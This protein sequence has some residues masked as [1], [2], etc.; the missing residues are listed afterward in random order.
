MSQNS[1]IDF[2]A[3]DANKNRNAKDYWKDRLQKLQFAGYFDSIKQHVAKDLRKSYLLVAP[4]NLDEM[5][6][7]MAPSGNSRHIL[8]LSGLVAFIRKCSSAEDITILTPNF[9]L[10]SESNQSEQN[11]IVPIR[12]SENREETVIEFIGRMK[13]LV[14]QDMNHSDYPLT[15]M[16]GM[17][18]Q[19]LSES[20]LIGFLLKE[21]QSKEVFD[22]LEPELLFEV[23]FTGGLH[24][25]LTYSNHYVTEGIE[26]MIQRFWEFLQRM[27]E[28]RTENLASLEL[29]SSKEKSLIVDV[30]NA[31]EQHFP[32]DKTLI[33]LFEEQVELNPHQRAVKCGAESLSYQQLNEKANQVAHFLTNKFLE[34]STVIG[35]FMDRSVDLIVAIFGILKAGHVYLPL[36]KD[37]PRERSNFT[38]ENSGA[39]LVF[40]DVLDAFDTVDCCSVKSTENQPIHYTSRLLPEDL[41]YI[42]YTSGSTGTP[43]GVLIKHRSIVNRINWMQ[44]EYGLSPEDVILQKTPTVFDVSVWELFWW[45][46]YGAQLV[47][48]DPGAEKDP[49]KLATTIEAEQIT[50]MH[51]VPSMLA[52]FVNHVFQNETNH[53]LRSLKMV[54][55]SGEELKPNDAQLLLQLCGD[56]RLHNLYGPTEATVDVSY[57]EVLRNEE[58][59]AIP[60]GKP[61]H[62]TTLLIVNHQFQLQPIG[63]PGELLIGGENLSVGYLNRPELTAEK[64]IN[65]PFKLGEKLYRTGDL[66]RWMPDGNIEY[67][68]RIDNQVKIRGNRIELGEIEFILQSFLGIEQAIV[69]PKNNHD[70][71][72]LVGY[73]KSEIAVDEEELFRFLQA[74]IPEYMIPSYFIRISEIPLTVNGKVDRTYLL[75]LKRESKNVIVAPETATEKLLFPLWESV[76]GTEAF[77]VLDSFFRIGGDSILAVRLI[78][79][80]NSRLNRTLD[81]NELYENDTIRSLAIILDSESKQ[82]VDFNEIE[83]EITAFGRNYMELSVNPLI[84]A[85]YPMSDIEKAMCYIHQSRPDDILYF[86]QIMQHVAYK[87]LN[88]AVLQSALD[89]LI[90]R[91]EILRT[92]F[93]FDQFAHV[94]YKTVSN[95]LIVHDLTGIESDEQKSIILTN[96]ENA[97]KTHFDLKSYPLWRIIVYKLGESHHELLYEYHHAIFDGWSVASFTTELNNTYAALMQNEFDGI[98]P[99]NCSYLDYIK[100][101]FASK[102]NTETR[103]YWVNELKNY[104]KLELN[105]YSDAKQFFSIREEY[106]HDLLQQLTLVCNREGTTVKML[107]L[108]AYIYAL[109]TLSGQQDILVGLI[110]FNRPLQT[111]GD[112]LLGCFLNEVPFRLTFEENEQLSW[113]SLLRKVEQKFLEV[114]KHD[115]LSLFEINQAIGA[116]TYHGNPL[117]DTT[118]NFINWHIMNE[119]ELQTIEEEN[120]DTVDFD[121]F[122]RG[123]TSFDANYNVNDQ[124][125]L[126]MHEFATP[127]MSQEVYAQYNSLFLHALTKL[128]NQPSGVLEDGNWFWENEANQVVDEMAISGADQL[129][130]LLRLLPDRVRFWK[131]ELISW[132]PTI[133]TD[134]AANNV[135]NGIASVDYTLPLPLSNSI[136]RKCNL[137]GI[138][139]EIFMSA[140]FNLLLH[141]LTGQSSVVTGIGLEAKSF[142]ELAN[143]LPFGFITTLTSSTKIDEYLESCF[144]TYIRTSNYA[145][146]PFESVLDKIGE[147]D[148]A[149]KSCFTIALGYREKINGAIQQLYSEGHQ[150]Q[151]T[152]NLIIELRRKESNFHLIAHYNKCAYTEPFIQELAL[153][154]HAVLEQ[155][156]TDSVQQIAEI[157]VLFAEE[158]T[159]ILTLNASSV[160]YP[161]QETIHFNF[162]KQVQRCPENIAL[163]FNNVS[164]TYRELND[165]ADHLANVIKNSGTLKGNTVGICLKRSPEMIIAILAVLKSGCV[166]VPIDPLLPDARCAYII[167]DSA[168]KLLLTASDII[169]IG[170]YEV[171][172]LY[173]DEIMSRK[174]EINP[175]EIEVN[176]TD[177]AYIIYTSGS[178]GM[179]K[180]VLVNH[181]SVVNLI[182]AQIQAFG[183]TEDERILQFAS[184]SFDA[185][186]EQI[187]LALFNGIPLVLISEDVLIDQNRFVEYVSNHKITHLHATPSFLETITLETPNHLKRIVAGGEQCSVQLVKKF[188]GDYAFYNEY[189]PTET[190]VT[191]TMKRLNEPILEGV[192]PIGKPI[193]N[194]TAY[195]LGSQMEL[196]PIGYTGELYLGGS[197]LTNGYIHNASLTQKQFVPNPFIPNQKLYKTGDLARYLPDG[198]IVYEGRIDNQVKI[199]GY[200]IELG[201]IEHQVN[202]FESIKQSYATVKQ[203]GDDKRI[204]V[205]YVAESPEASLVLETYLANRLP[206]YMLPAYYVHLTGFE[207]N[208]NGKLD[209]SNLPDPELKTQSKSEVPLSDMEKTM[210]AVWAEILNLTI[211][212]ISIDAS[213]FELGGNSLLIVKLLAAIR[214]ELNWEISIPQLFGASTIKSLIAF[215]TSTDLEQKNQQ[216]QIEMEVEEMESILNLFDTNNEEI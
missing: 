5:I 122:L 159:H 66:A 183:I 89:Q 177:P 108:T 23:G 25:N 27:L 158:R 170:K 71:L 206:S 82:S 115:F 194:T 133:L 58:Y 41:A 139:E 67:L 10:G 3:L 176:S 138:T 49:A 187:W 178:T 146:V 213:F 175:I 84:E 180:G 75:G 172:L 124:R 59:T 95:K 205:Y 86:E 166:Y 97:R 101:E 144:N 53:N 17:S 117:F 163:I 13:S 129:K 45:A 208:R 73:I 20:P 9:S 111:D 209:V 69:L 190:T 164:L 7:T 165:K 116:L 215:V 173:L 157:D 191:S 39:K 21:E 47:L 195:I 110:T 64:F 168:Q 104:K 98:E 70:N 184:I 79:M 137:S 65:H 152:P 26:L 132:Q 16:T 57:Y 147:T 34:K 106:P 51:F 88:L 87:N 120:L 112:K 24:L 90:V 145:D 28:H 46:M 114:K 203:Y 6:T 185:S 60:I 192:I 52:V 136:L 62:N 216:Q 128:I 130:P 214:K 33:H 38:L 77:G 80:I 36:S 151:N 61:I 125:I 42:I 22:T 201:E 48:A 200:R 150:T 134:S 103:A 126:C 123:N 99:L 127:F 198:D 121:S 29:I 169:S 148:A 72:H 74:K 102:R 40:T 31:T 18:F 182:Y 186:V 197:G 118:F 68:G 131:E 56:V 8:L 135:K 156:I 11:R 37:Y 196:L 207:L 160:A 109:K 199:R 63:I 19:E 153:R 54:F 171:E 210:V 2:A 143:S 14:V 94:I 1:N 76:L 119:M 15:K 107:L 85:V 149:L 188:A 50:V 140:T 35:V 113:V 174:D 83:A 78:G 212:E 30:F 189:G 91:H 4:S 154:F 167:E 142:S 44:H 92:G 162:E 32:T 55:A 211:E 12:V 202:T 81:M 161:D 141:K 43:K 93:D 193:N 100:Q 105:A 179:P 181:T 155:M 96:L 204:I